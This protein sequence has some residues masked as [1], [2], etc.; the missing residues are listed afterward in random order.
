MFNGCCS[1][2]YL[3]RKVSKGCNASGAEV[4][5]DDSVLQN[6]CFYQYR[7]KVYETL[8]STRENKNFLVKL[9]L[10]AIWKYLAQK[11]VQYVV[12]GNHITY[13][14]RLG[15]LENNHEEADTLLIH[16]LA[17]CTN[18]SSKALLVYASDVDIAM[19]LI[20]HRNR[21]AFKSIYFGFS[22]TKTDIDA[23]H[24]FLGSNRV[25]CILALHSLTGCDTVGKFNNVSK[26]KW[27]K[28]FLQIEDEG[29]LQAFVDL[30]DEIQNKT[31][32]TLATFICS[33]YVNL[34]KIP[35]LKTLA[36]VRV[37]MYKQKNANCEKIPPTY[38][39]F[40]YHALRAFHQLRQW[41]TACES[42]IDVRDPLE[43]GWE[44]SGDG[45]FVPSTTDSDFAPNT[46]IELVSC[47]CNKG[48]KKSC[49]CSS[50]GEPCTDLCGCG[51]NC[52]N[53][54]PNMSESL[55][56]EDLFFT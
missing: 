42:V 17:L 34:K 6:K 15:E 23:V 54:D 4:K 39:S 43:C 28:L 16:C 22:E 11:G 26:E 10:P 40:R 30:T 38:G 9:L 3:Q 19:L 47:N 18:V 46:L 52:Q 55:S 32:Y 27:A 49:G 24:S 48:C 31:I 13:H 1:L 37:H 5:V 33:G 29:M 14:W 51:T 20:A 21:L 50:H 53:T 8:A 41:K 36:S 12:A 56:L 25:N 7:K 2:R 45:K 35:Q 44:D